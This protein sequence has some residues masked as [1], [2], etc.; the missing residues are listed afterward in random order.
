MKS[1]SPTLPYRR[2]LDLDFRPGAVPISFSSAEVTSERLPSAAENIQISFHG[3]LGAIQGDQNYVAFSGVE[4]DSGLFKYVQGKDSSKQSKKSRLAFKLT[5]LKPPQATIT[6][7]L[8]VESNSGL[9]T[10][11]K[12][13]PEIL[14]THESPKIQIPL[15][16]FCLSRRGSISD[17]QFKGDGEIK[18]VRIFFK[19]S[20]NSPQSTEPIEISFII[21]SED[22]SL[23]IF[24]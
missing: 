9:T 10:Y 19:R 15:N 24:K 16:E 17:Q 22:L 1:L 23:E 8:V 11:E 7:Q 12:N 21:Q 6:V 14:T 4:L 20:L 2:F 13:L 5:E 3:K 18:L